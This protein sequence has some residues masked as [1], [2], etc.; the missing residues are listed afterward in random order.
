LS[1]GLYFCDT[2]L[3]HLL[4]MAIRYKNQ[5]FCNNPRFSADESFKCPFTL[6]LM[7]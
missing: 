7:T 2:Q 4:R 3:A 1:I 6:R 5:E